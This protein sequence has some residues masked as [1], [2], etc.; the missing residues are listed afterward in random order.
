MDRVAGATGHSAPCCSRL[1]ILCHL[2]PAIFAGIATVV[3]VF[4]RREDRTPWWDRDATGRIVAA[5]LV[6][7]TLLVLVPGDRVPLIGG[8]V[9]QIAPQW[10][11]PAVASV[12]ALALFTGAQPAVLDVWRGPVGRRRA[13]G[14]ALLAAGALLVALAAGLVDASPWLWVLVA[15]GVAI[16]VVAGWDTRLVRWLLPVA[17][18][19]IAATMFW[20]LPFLSNS[21][22]MNDMGWERYTRYTEHLL[23]DPLPDLSLAGMPYRNVVYGLAGLGILLALLQRVRLGWFLALV[24]TA[25]AW[26]FRYFPQY[27]LWNARLLPF[28]YLALYLLAGLAVA[29]V[30]RAI[31]IG[32]GELRRGGRPNR[33]SSVPQVSVSSPS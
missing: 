12:V 31:V 25:L 28:L 21:T 10:L 3:L 13:L 6:G 26:I 8:L 30:I 29:L 2:I 16:A 15:I 1:T 27:R 33:S 32:V 14:V 11:F 24:V 5:A 19:G 18:A 23:A 17:P 22:F 4:V 20:S 9:D 7:Y